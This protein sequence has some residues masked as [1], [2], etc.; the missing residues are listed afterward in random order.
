MNPLKGRVKRMIVKSREQKLYGQL[1]GKKA[2][3]A[4]QNSSPEL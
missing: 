4:N 2:I 3:E 1:I